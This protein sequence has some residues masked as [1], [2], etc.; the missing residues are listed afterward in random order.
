[1]PEG[2]E[3][4]VIAED[5]DWRDKGS[6]AHFSPFLAHEWRTLKKKDLHY[7]RSLSSFFK[8]KYPDIKVSV[9]LEK[10]LLIESLRNAGTF[11]TA[12][13]VLK[14]LSRYSDFT[15]SQIQEDRG[16]RDDKQSGLL[17]RR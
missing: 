14:S 13:S 9:E 6:D 16:G 4:Y 7:Y 10:E 17:D 12:R 1:M 3:F 11:K 8:D 15:D 2:E 5:K